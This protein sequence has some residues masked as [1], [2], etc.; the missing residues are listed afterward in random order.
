MTDTSDT[1]LGLDSATLD[2][3]RRAGIE[4]QEL[5]ERLAR[6]EFQA[7]RH[8]LSEEDPFSLRVELGGV[9]HVPDP[10][11]PAETLP[12]FHADE[13]TMRLLP[14]LPVP[15]GRIAWTGRPQDLPVTGILVGPLEERRLADLLLALLTEHH[16]TPFARLVFLCRDLAPVHVLGRYGLISHDIGEA[17][18][19]YVAAMMTWRY[20]MVQVRALEDGQK[21][22][23]IPV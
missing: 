2:L 23:Q 19:E 18:L 4:R 3:L 11:D 6:H 9:P 12:E 16:R 5:G 20:G 10:R 15:L 14:K 7:L 22:W 8:E 13:S 21:L 17:P 1:D